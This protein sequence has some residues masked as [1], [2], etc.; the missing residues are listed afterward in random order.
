MPNGNGNGPIPFKQD[1]IPIVGQ[2]FTLKSGFSV[3]TVVCNCPAREP[4]TLLANLPNACPACKR[5]FV[6]AAFSINQQGQ[7]QAAIGLVQQQQP[8]DAPVGVGV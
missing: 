8:A 5:S 2:L 1:G 6:V 4:V 7:V 3:V